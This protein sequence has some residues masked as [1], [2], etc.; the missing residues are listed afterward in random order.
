VFFVFKTK[1]SFLS[2]PWCLDA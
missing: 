1:K 2:V